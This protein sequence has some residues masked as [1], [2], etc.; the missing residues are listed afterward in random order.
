MEICDLR[1]KIS[2]L[3]DHFAIK[4]FLVILSCFPTNNCPHL[5][6]TSGFSIPT[7]N[8]DVPH[9]ACRIIIASRNPSPPQRQACHA[10]WTV[11]RL[12]S[13]GM[14]FLLHDFDSF[15]ETVEGE[16]LTQ[17]MSG[18]VQSL[19][20]IRDA[21]SNMW[22]YHAHSGSNLSRSLSRNHQLR[23]SHLFT[24][25]PTTISPQTSDPPIS[26]SPEHS[27]RSAQGNTVTFPPSD[28]HTD[29][30]C[31]ADPP[32]PRRPAPRPHRE[33]FFVSSLPPHSHTPHYRVSPRI[34]T[35][36]LHHSPLTSGQSPRSHCDASATRAL[37]SS[38]VRA[39]RYV[40]VPS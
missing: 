26:V 19:S 39:A 14:A 31:V 30:S 35:N 16:R 23:P 27:T 34:G 32:P 12:T 28:G 38:L 17:D 3:L 11:Q 20:Y 7:I 2:L 29:I 37:Y 4:F 33:V 8:P 6:T 21:L 10:G 36:V 24:S 15:F 5:H 25:V 1:R 18:V 40:V 9:Q 13:G 22:E